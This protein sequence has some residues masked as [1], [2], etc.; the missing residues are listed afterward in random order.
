ME[1]KK[2]ILLK[3]TREISPI[4]IKQKFFKKKE[5]RKEKKKKKKKKWKTK[6]K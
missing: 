5:K 2:A 6:E 4:K 1:T 3:I